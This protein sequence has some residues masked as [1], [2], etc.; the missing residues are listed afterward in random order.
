[1]KRSD[2]IKPGQDADAAAAADG[3]VSASDTA[4]ATPFMAQYLE[5]KAR[6]PDALL[7]FRMGDFYELFFEDAVLAA[8]ALDIT[9]T[10]R[11]AHAGQPIPMAGVPHHAAEGYLAK[12]IRNGFRVAV[13]E[14]VEDP[15][16]AR[17]RGS[18]AVVRREVVRL[19][20]PGTLTEDTLLDARSSSC[21]AAIGL[22]GGGR[23]AALALADVSTGRLEVFALAPA[24]LE[25]AL[26]AVGPNEV[27][28]SD[29]ASQHADVKRATA[30]Q[31]VT[32]RPEARADA[33]A[34]ER[35]MKAAYGVGDLAGFGGFTRAELVACALLFDYLALTQAGAAA[36][37]DPPIRQP[38]GAFV[39]IDPAT[40]ASLEIERTARGGRQGSLVASIDR[41]VTAGGARLLGQ[42]V[43]R[44]LR[45][46]GEIERRLDAVAFF[47]DAADR[48]DAVRKE[49][50]Q[51]ADL[52]RARMRLQ[53]RR[54]GPRDLLALK[55]A[56]EA[57]ERLSAELVGAGGAPAE[58]DEGRRILTVA[59]RPRLA[60]FVQTLGAALAGELPV[61]AKDGGFIAAGF[62]PGLDV[63]RPADA[64]VAGTAG[65][66]DAFS[67]TFA[68]GIA[69]SAS[70]EDAVIAAA[71]NAASVIGY[72]DT[73]SG[74]LRR[75]DVDA[76]VATLRGTLKLTHWTR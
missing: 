37:L 30:A 41:T 66:G 43:S 62:D 4:G 70:A 11:G 18:R 36:R 75:Q 26:A 16:E 50:K 45:D 6:H 23:E 5:M 67:A 65:A 19:V 54:G 72:L 71:A 60:A 29:G 25:E 63:V 59:A 38:A 51:S 74:L 31:V 39:S 8:A 13:C 9:Q 40:R 15:S 28:V 58:V 34:G 24:D 22:A 2:P 42:R 61:T 57:G 32:P 68:A 7:F 33:R 14:Q 17:K 12:L 35:L 20:T 21:L 49:L 73:Q 10:F 48:R 56:L 64:L 27:L 76:R 47:L 69:T 44:P 52:E 55:L 3:A 1:M 53:L 46:R